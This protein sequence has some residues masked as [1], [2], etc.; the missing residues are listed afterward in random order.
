MMGLARTTPS[1]EA[2]WILMAG[3]VAHHPGLLRP[4]TYVPLPAELEPL[5]PAALQGCARDAPFLALPKGE[6]TVHHDLEGVART[7]EIVRALDGRDDVWVVLSH[8]A[9]LDEGTGVRWLPEAANGWR[10]EGVK[11]KTRWRWL[12][13]GNMAYRW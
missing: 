6:G 7:L 10:A 3:D 5:V 13:K 9:S 2:T 8:D 4:S 11:E 1:P 12:E